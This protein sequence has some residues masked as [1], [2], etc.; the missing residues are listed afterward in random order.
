MPT[1]CPSSGLV[2]YP[3]PI[4][5]FVSEL[6]IERDIFL[7]CTYHLKQMGTLLKFV[8]SVLLSSVGILLSISI[9]LPE[10]FHIFFCEGLKMSC[11]VILQG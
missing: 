9:F 11:L 8:L 2:Y 1:T 5:L 6:Y 7:I 4:S 10:G 3:C